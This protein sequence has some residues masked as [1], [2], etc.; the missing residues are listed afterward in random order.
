MH[1]TRERYAMGVGLAQSGEERRA[2]SGDGFSEAFGE[3]EPR[4]SSRR[5]LRVVWL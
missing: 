3:A 5:S 1:D 2:G 4:R